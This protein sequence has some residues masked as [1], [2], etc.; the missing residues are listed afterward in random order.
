MLI[1]KVLLISLVAF[2]LIPQ[3]LATV[4]NDSTKLKR[5][6]VGLVMSGG[7]AKGFAYVG[8][9]KVLE[10]VNMPI[11]YIGGASMGAITAALYSVGY[12]PET[13]M[14]IIRAQDWNSFIS[15]V[16]HR[17]YIAYEEKL[18]NDKY[19]FSLPLEGEGISLSRSIN[20]SFNID[21]ILN[22]LFAPAANVTDFNDLA[23]PFLCIGT[24]LLT[25]EAV[26]L[27]KGNL[28]RAVRASMAIPGYF[29]PTKYD[30]RYL[31]DGGVVNNYPAEQVKA[32]GADIIIGA[33][34]QSGLKSS[35]DEINSITGILDQVISF[36]RVDANIKG[37]ELTD[38]Y[39][40][41]GMPYGMMDFDK[42]DSIMAIGERIAREHYPSLKALADSLNGLGDPAPVRKRVQ[43]I[44][45]L[46][47][48]KFEWADM[49]LKSSEK[50]QAYFS[51]GDNK[52]IA[53]SELENK[54]LLLNGT[55]NF[56]DLRYEFIPVDEDT[57]N[58]KIEAGNANKGSIAAGINYNS[59]YGG[60]VLL[61]L[62][63][64][65][66][67]GTNAKLFTDVVLGQNPRIKSMFIINNGFKPGFGLEADL[68]AL[69]FPEYEKGDKVNKWDFD[70]LSFAAFM[71]LTI[72][73]NYLIRTGFQYELFRFKQD[74]VVD[75][76][77]EAYNKFADYGNLFF[78][79]QHDS[80]NK[81]DYA[82]KGQ[83]VQFQI[84]HVFPF[85]DQWSD[86]M[87]NGTILSM[88]YNW[89]LSLGE[90]LVYK[91]QLF[92]GYT[93]TEKNGPYSEPS[94]SNIS[95]R[96]P[97]VQHMFGFGGIGSNNYVPG[98]VSFTGFNYLERM[99]MFAGKVTTDFE[100]NIYPKI[101]ASL[102]A[103]V[104]F[105]E[106]DVSD[107]SNVKVLVGYGA[108]LSY[109]SFIGPVD[110]ILSSSNIDTSIN[111]FVNV[112]FWF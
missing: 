33:D 103:D 24:D 6:K 112:G 54:M 30:G 95:R 85:S 83:F 26:V 88:Q 102:M 46:T 21:L 10:E 31:I 15:D 62:S 35:I 8:L 69:S 104:G 91:P 82:T 36:N 43:P 71:P 68:Y 34:V 72:K 61:N 94:L 93:F 97:A 108:K 66:I 105:L 86:V 7:G 76:E 11:D 89:Y 109:N 40:K 65:N 37:L 101:Y 39:V 107:F 19:I 20:S 58:V 28:A 67:R 25:G 57:L 23:I 87:S 64:R 90:K 81:V 2:I 100:Y 106:N 99:G 80:R 70:M 49:K 55:R 48:N 74:V 96:V 98:H 53:L 41:I 1:R 79:F 59:V 56:D 16:Q 92:A 84:K 51:Y 17:R 73:N 45:S 27:T 9:L 52:E 5:P 13:I 77:Y 29:S 60:S 78:T 47:V 18:F 50:Y 12:S 38:Y 111:M 44:E 22:K 14:E 110:F 75:P 32:M 42:Y 3:V 4:Q 63:L